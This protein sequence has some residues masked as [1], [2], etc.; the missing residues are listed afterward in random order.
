[1]VDAALKGSEGDGSGMTSERWPQRAAQADE[2]QM[3]S[4]SA[5]EH[6]R[7]GEGEGEGE[8]EGQG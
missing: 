7:Q 6:L 5:P 3:P 4:L 2:A 1:M 8:G